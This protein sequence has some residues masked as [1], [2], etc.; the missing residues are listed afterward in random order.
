[1]G[2]NSSNGDWAAFMLPAFETDFLD[3]PMDTTAWPGYGAMDS[4]IDDTP[5]Q[6]RQQQQQQQQTITRLDTREGGKRCDNN[7]PRGSSPEDTGRTPLLACPYFRSNPLRYHD[8]QHMKLRR[9]KDVKQHISRRHKDPRYRCSCSQDTSHKLPSGAFSRSK[10]G[11]R[12]CGLYNGPDTATML[13]AE[14][15]KLLSH[16][17]TSRNKSIESQWYHIWDIIF[18]RTRPPRAIYMDRDRRENVDSLRSLWEQKRSELVSRAMARLPL[19]PPPPPCVPPERD[20][21]YSIVD[22][23]FDELEAQ[24]FVSG[25]GSGR[26]ETRESTIE[27][28]I[29]SPSEFC[30]MSTLPHDAGRVR[31]QVDTI[32]PTLNSER[33]DADVFPGTYFSEFDNASDGFGY[34]PWS[35]PLENGGDPGLGLYAVAVSGPR[36]VTVVTL[37]VGFSLFSLSVFRPY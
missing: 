34:G 1:M 7:T 2:F 25:D 26:E 22:S 37:P 20:L 24:M 27:S 15:R 32:N 31:V 8:C 33:E 12:R 6:Q 13:S 30:S 21:L 4:T 36:L 29:A 28:A 11:R 16:H 14:Q 35:D 3:Y 23:V 9:I 18:P 17:Y 19:G 5:R 10:T